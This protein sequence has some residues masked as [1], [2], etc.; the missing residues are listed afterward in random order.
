MNRLLLLICVLFSSSTSFAQNY[1]VHANSM[2][3]TDNKYIFQ[4]DV[5]IESEN[6]NLKADNLIVEQELYL[7]TGS[8]AELN[9]IEENVQANIVGNNLT[10]NK[11]QYLVQGSPAQLYIIENDLNAY[12]LGEEISY[13]G[14]N[15]LIELTNGGELK[16]NDLNITA[17]YINFDL[18][19]QTLIANQQVSFVEETLLAK[20]ISATANL[21]QN[22][23]NVELLGEPAEINITN[24]LAEGKL[25]AT[26][27]LIEFNE[28]TNII[29]LTGNAIANLGTERIEGESITFDVAKGEFVVEPSEGGRVKATIKAR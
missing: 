27:N 6:L 16:L 24:N 3:A 8:P 13:S 19:S 21:T 28:N 12:L 5:I 18:N 26:A 2:E 22:N 25:I 10:M 14:E 11:D 7:I 15:N 29:Q 17:G 20:A 4:G 23:I 9:I 1:E